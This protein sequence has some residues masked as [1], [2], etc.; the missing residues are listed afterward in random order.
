MAQINYKKILDKKGFI[1]V[2][3]QEPIS[4]DI[5]KEFF[6]LKNDNYLN[7]TKWIFRKRSF[8]EGSIVKS[9][10][11]WTKKN[12]FFQPKKINKFVGGV[13]RKF[14]ML[15]RPLKKFIEN[16]LNNFF[17][18]QDLFSSKFKIGA[19]AIRIVCNKKNKGYP[20]PEG[21]HTDGVNYVAIVPINFDKCKGGI[22]YLK[23]SKNNKIVLKKKL[24]KKILLFNDNKLLHYATP[25]NINQGTLGFRDIFVITFVKR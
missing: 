7:N 3:T 20:V 19:H 25:I 12:T 21:F 6:K 2:D 9:K 14:P 13:I 24:D 23:N 15:S 11:T 22:S 10:L 8:A 1:L 17:L 16:L 18:K 4:E 5:K